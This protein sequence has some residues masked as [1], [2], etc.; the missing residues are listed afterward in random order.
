MKPISSKLR[1]EG[2]L[3]VIYLDDMFL[4]GLSYEECK[5]NMERTLF[6]L[7]QAGFII[8]YKKF[9]LEPSTNIKFLGF[10][11]NS[12]NMTVTLPEDKK[13]NIVSLCTQ[14]SSGSTFSI[15]LVSKFI[16]IL[17]SSLSCSTIWSFILP[18]FGT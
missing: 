15:R 16:G 2:F 3:S 12:V 10:Y 11:I 7:S 6:I 1:N 8:N 4:V 17:V 14:L 9:S 5:E 13:L 18:V